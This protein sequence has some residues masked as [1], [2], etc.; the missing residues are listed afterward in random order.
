MGGSATIIAQTR[1]SERERFALYFLPNIR[2]V[3]SFPFRTNIHRITRSIMIRFHCMP[4]AQSSAKNRCEMQAADDER[5]VRRGARASHHGQW[6]ITCRSMDGSKI[7]R[8]SE[9]KYC[10]R[11]RKLSPA[12]FNWSGRSGDLSTPA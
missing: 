6:S 9:R 1:E 5:V 4:A 3:D 11:A 12:A 8:K 2:K 7:E 10:G